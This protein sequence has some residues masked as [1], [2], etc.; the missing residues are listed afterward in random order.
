MPAPWTGALAASALLFLAAVPLWA[1]GGLSS[2][3]VL[4]G[5]VERDAGGALMVTLQ[6]PDRD[7]VPAL[8]VSDGVLRVPPGYLVALPTDAAI[9]AKAPDR[10]PWFAVGTAPPG[11]DG[12]RRLSD[13]ST[14]RDGEVVP[15]RPGASWAED[16]ARLDGLGRRCG[17]ELRSEA[18]GDVVLGLCPASV[19]GPGDVLLLAAGPDWLEVERE[20]GF[21]QERQ[22]IAPLAV[23]CALGAAVAAVLLF[24]GLGAAAAV[25]T[26]TSVVL[27]ML[28]SPVGGPVGG[29]IAFVVGW[30]ASAA[31]AAREP[32]SA[33]RLAL[34]SPLLVL[35]ALPMLAS[36]E[37]A[38]VV[39]DQA[40][41]TLTG[42]STAEGHGLRDGTAMPAQRLQAGCPACSEGADALARGGERFDFVR[43][44]LC[45]APTSL[46]GRTVIFLGGGNDDLLWGLEDGG[47]L[48]GPGRAF[49]QLRALTGAIAGPEASERF[50]EGGAASSRAGFERQ[51]AVLHEGLACAAS[52]NAK[53]VFVQDFLAPDLAGGRAGDRRWM[54]ERRRELVEASGADFMDLADV[55]GDRAGVWTFS[56]FIHLS[57]AAHD[58]LVPA[59]CARIEGAPGATRGRAADDPAPH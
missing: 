35:G 39:S 12:V 59:L 3:V 11:P 43:D 24:W 38:G 10:A 58:E 6:A 9:S 44:Q 46:E 55:Y 14:L 29:G 13:A 48:A 15:W 56:D 50:Y 57:G 49:A 32:R 20:G 52:R 17:T 53:L 28:L 51:A 42:Y 30:I 8:D 25:T 41:C 19:D 47:A 40:A 27:V 31:R 16:R 45:S 34:L 26:A 1:P 23:G 7:M 4:R 36:E 18:G 22:I 37:P 21:G 33:A 5:Q 2:D 54:T